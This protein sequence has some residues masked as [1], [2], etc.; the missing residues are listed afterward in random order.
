MG[1][2][3]KK[4]IKGINYYYYVESKRIDGKPRL[5]NQ[6]YLGT[7]D[8]VLEKALLAN[9]PLQDRVLYSVETVVRGC[10]SPL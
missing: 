2:I 6:K 5:V 8:K 7:A 3:I 10:S 1:T 9:S 4:K